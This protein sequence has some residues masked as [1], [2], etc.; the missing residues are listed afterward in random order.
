MS[1]FENYLIATDL[2]GTFFAKGGRT[3]PRN[4]EAVERFCRNG[5]RFTIATGRL[6]R[7]IR[8][9]I[10]HPEQLCNAPIVMSNGAYLYDFAT[11]TATHSRFFA[12]ADAR[13]VLRF[14]KENF[15]D[16]QFRV[17]GTDEFRIEE[18]SGFLLKDS[19]RFD[20][21]AVQISP[22]E[23]WRFDDWYKLVFRAELDRIA[24]VRPMLEAA[25]S[26]RLGITC[27]G[28]RT[29]E[30]QPKECSKALG[31]VY[32]RDYLKEIGESRRII[33]CGDFEND[34]EMLQAADI[35]VCPE[36][37]LPQ[38]KAVADYVLCNCNDG[39]I[40]NVI[41]ELERGGIV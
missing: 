4:L 10:P 35:A 39:L 3:V 32:L 37:A 24:E 31:L 21:G 17:S 36:N 26:D 2:D 18:M 8:V 38:V 30:I 20:P 27:S 19:Q 13:D 5:G 40:A 14:A 9:A 41:E 12:E 29:I 28:S 11:N 33:A 6:H 1:I 22:S 7:N 23:T 25:F 15:P 34:I 16:V